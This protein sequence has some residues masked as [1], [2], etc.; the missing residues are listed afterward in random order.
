MTSGLILVAVIVVIL[1]RINWPNFVQFSMQLGVLGR[2][3]GYHDNNA[4]WFAQV[5]KHYYSWHYGENNVIFSKIQTCIQ[6]AVGHLKSGYGGWG[7][8]VS[9]PSRVLGRALAEIKFDAYWP[10]NLP[11]GGNN[12][13][14]F[15]KN[16]LFKFCAV[17]FTKFAIVITMPIGYPEW[18]NIITAD[19][20]KKHDVIFSKRQACIQSKLLSYF[21]FGGHVPP[22]P[23][24]EIHLCD[25]LRHQTKWLPYFCIISTLPAGVEYDTCY[26]FCKTVY[27]LSVILE[28]SSLKLK[29]R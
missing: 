23:H 2:L 16:Q 26:F 17:F 20:M 21:G 15:A 7:S 13:N 14:D 28:C 22:M 4:N 25:N 8:T 27:F 3:V 29:T 1:L 10:W 9:S 19:T 12:F 11:A 18:E 6:S 24:M 5:R